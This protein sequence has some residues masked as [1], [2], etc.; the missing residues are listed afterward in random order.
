[1]LVEILRIGSK[2]QLAMV[3]K[4]NLL[5]KMVKKNNNNQ[6]LK[7]ACIRGI[8]GQIQFHSLKIFVHTLICLNDMNLENYNDLVLQC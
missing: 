6:L 2:L 3:E 1:M 4:I 5:L 7:T 8:K